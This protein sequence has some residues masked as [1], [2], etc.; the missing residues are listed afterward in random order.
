MIELASP[1]LSREH[2]SKAPTDELCPAV[3]GGANAV[4]ESAVMAA[5][6]KSVLFM[7]S[8]PFVPPLSGI[9]NLD[10]PSGQHAT[11]ATPI[12]P[13]LRR[14]S[15]TALKTAVVTRSSVKLAGTASVRVTSWLDDLLK[16]DAASRE[17][18][19]QAVRCLQN[20]AIKTQA[21]VAELKRGVYSD[22]A[23]ERELAFA[24]QQAS[25]A[26]YGL[27]GPL[28]ERLQ[29][30]GEYWTQPESWTDAQVRDA[31]ISFSM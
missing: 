8:L 6:E 1:L 20:A 12:V 13:L 4:I 30:K 23:T 17:R 10:V 14:T 25:S 21:Y 15:F 3:A 2:T 27:D 5:T 28:A 26:F 22:R 24:W 16:A 19:K 29:L 31:N 18:W 7:M 11:P 9:S